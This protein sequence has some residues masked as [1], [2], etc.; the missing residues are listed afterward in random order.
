MY[1]FLEKAKALC[2]LGTTYTH[3][4]NFAEAE[5]HLE[6][7]LEIAK[8]QFDKSSHSWAIRLTEIL[9]KLGSMKRKRGE[10][11]EAL[12]ILTHCVDLKNKH[13]FQINH[14]GQ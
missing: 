3:L 2:D 7:A 8:K 1:I 11:N 12:D 14:P 9:E 4:C 13:Y 5:T 10:V 6:Q